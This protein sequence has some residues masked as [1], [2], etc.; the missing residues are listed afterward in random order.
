MMNGLVQVRTPTYRRPEA[1]RRALGSLI[2]QSWPHW[3]ADVCDDDPEQAGR[4]VVEA[5]GDDRIR[6][7]HNTPQRYASS[8]IDACFSAVNPSNAGPAKTAV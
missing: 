1:L 5:L 3:V 4:A 7:H 8:N 2:A 6:Y